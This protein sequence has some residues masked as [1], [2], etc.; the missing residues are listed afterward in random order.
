MK[1]LLVYYT[2]TYN[3]RFLTDKVAERFER[4][5]CEVDRVEITS[6]SVAVGLK[7]YEYVGLGYPVY[8]FN[9]P[10]PFMKYF[11]KLKF[12]EGQKYFIYKNSGETLAI[13]NASSRK[14]LRRM[15]RFG[16]SFCGEYHFVMPYNIH[17]G[18]DENFIKHI[19]CEDKK[20]LDILFY[21]L[22]HSIAPR[23]KSN[24][25]YNFSAF[26]VGI[27][28]IGG[29][30]NSFFYK[31]DKSK[32]NKC[33]LCAKN[34][35]HSNISINNG[36]VKFGHFCDMCMRC[37]FYCPKKAIKIGFLQGW[38]V[39]NYYD[40]P[41]LWKDDSELTPYITEKSSGFYKCFIRTFNEI[42]ARYAEIIS[43]TEQSDG[44]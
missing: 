11:N 31:V 23:I 25:V 3:T 43:E 34:C 36:K 30:V 6:S 15:N 9:A 28:S 29:A 19:I 37:S 12:F 24:F 41:R 17:F 20:L 7:G 8:G 5:G 1:V 10:H 13:N 27:Q 22:S 2:G 38:Q 44:K 16:A 40:L 21:N 32:C 4:L 14:I 26:F 35:P 33:G 39:N 18:Y 42:D